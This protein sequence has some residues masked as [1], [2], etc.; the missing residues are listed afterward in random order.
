[1]ANDTEL[2]RKQ[3]QVFCGGAGEQQ[4]SVFGTM[5]NPVP[6]YSKDPETLQGTNWPQGW[7]NAIAADDA[8]FMEDMNSL[9]Y[10]LSYM[11]KYLYQ[12]GIPE[13]SNKET[14]T[15]SKSVV[16]R[17]G[18]IYVAKQTTGADN[19]QDPATDSSNTYWYLALDPVN[20]PAD[21][22]W[23]KGYA[24][25]ISYEN[26]RT[27][28]CSG[29]VTVSLQDTDEVIKLNITDNSTISFDLSALTYSKSVYTVQ[30]YAVFPN[31]VKTIS[32][33]A[34]PSISWINDTTPDFSSG[35]QH[36]LVLRHISGDSFVLMSDAGEV[37]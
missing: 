24:K 37:A 26:I 17:N 34:T 36:W 6:D 3:I 16:L 23:V 5:K 12:H 8:P 35:K 21:Q 27:V 2:E 22:S 29:A 14:Y 30:I 19:P 18:K 31:G 4:T 20:A 11:T 13:W 28:D 32:L 33:S 10:V 25:N 15:A 9:F 7:Q 1:M